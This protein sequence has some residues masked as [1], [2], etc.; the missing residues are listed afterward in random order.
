MSSARLGSSLT[1]VRWARWLILASVAAGTLGSV[2]SLAC[3]ATDY[4]AITPE[5]VYDVLSARLGDMQIFYD[6]EF[7]C[8]G[9][10][11]ACNKESHA[12]DRRQG[13]DDAVRIR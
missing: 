3:S 7:R 9:R 6:T 11:T 2:P 8:A 4:T 10:A 1:P 12:R 5:T 13:R